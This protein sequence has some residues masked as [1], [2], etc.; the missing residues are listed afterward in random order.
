M[1]IN[2]HAAHAQSVRRPPDAMRD[3]VDHVVSRLSRWRRAPI[4]GGGGG[5]GAERGR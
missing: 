2:R 4:R 5:G 3:H 1:R